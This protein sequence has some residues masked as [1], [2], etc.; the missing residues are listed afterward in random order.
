MFCFLFSQIIFLIILSSKSC[1]FELEKKKVEV[2][3]TLITLSFTI[4]NQINCF[5]YIIS[6]IYGQ[7][8]LFNI[9]NWINYFFYIISTLNYMYLIIIWSYF[10]FLLFLNRYFMVFILINLL[11]FLDINFVYYVI[12]YITLHLLSPKSY[13]ARGWNFIKYRV[14][15]R[16][17]TI[18]KNI[19][20]LKDKN[21]IIYSFLC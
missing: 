20:T 1:H 13:R 12:K 11:F 8:I 2:E 6:T 5:L 10:M 14:Q 18:T 7:L 16:T 15:M 3:A 19:R 4:V 17:Q 21:D 9:V